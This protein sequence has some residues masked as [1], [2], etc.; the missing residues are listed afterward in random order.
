MPS[1]SGPYTSEGLSQK[2]Q[3]RTGGRR[4]KILSSLHQI[5]I[6]D[7][8]RESRITRKNTVCLRVSCMWHSSLL[9]HGAFTNT[10]FF[11]MSQCLLLARLTLSP[12]VVTFAWWEWRGR[13][14]VAFVR[15]LGGL[16]RRVDDRTTSPL[17]SLP[18]PVSLD[19]LSRACRIHTLQS[20]LL[21]E[22]YTAVGQVLRESVICLVSCVL[23]SRIYFSKDPASLPQ[24]VPSATRG[25]NP[26]QTTI[27]SR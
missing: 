10:P 11:V 27:V 12:Q 9:L 24:Q 8:S 13:C 7:F 25:H 14:L 20:P 17:S 23:V 4:N 2:C 19:C 5:R 22:P 16:A 6:P 3:T 21:R 15:C 26:S 1:Y 18:D